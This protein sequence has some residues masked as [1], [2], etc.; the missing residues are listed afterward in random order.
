MN[1][2]IL[3]RSDKEYRDEKKNRI[4][5]PKTR[6][7]DI[8]TYTLHVRIWRSGLRALDRR[9]NIFIRGIKFLQLTY[10]SY[11]CHVS[12]YCSTTTSSIDWR[13]VGTLGTRDAGKLNTL[14]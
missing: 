9:Q 2:L 1:D 7:F 11:T 14:Y 3:V 12:I 6:N 4:F 8:F 5:P 13:R 10:E